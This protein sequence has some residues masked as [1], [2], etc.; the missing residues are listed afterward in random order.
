MYFGEKNLKPFIFSMWQRLVLPHLNP[1]NQAPWV[2]TGKAP[3]D[4]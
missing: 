2:Q 4:Q 3:R 1:A